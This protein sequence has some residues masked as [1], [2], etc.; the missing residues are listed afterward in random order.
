[1]QHAPG[2][3]LPGACYA[4]VL[5]TVPLYVKPSSWRAVPNY[6]CPVAKLEG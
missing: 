5:R 6:L 4:W 2:V 1:M 3:I